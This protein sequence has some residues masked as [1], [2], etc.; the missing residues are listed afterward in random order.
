MT[1]AI[2]PARYGS[3]RLKGKPLIPV[4]GKP[5]IRRVYE[6]AKKAEHLSD[7][8]VATD[9]VRVKN[10]VEAFSGK[11]VLTES[12]LSSGTDRVARAAEI[13]EIPGD[14]IVVNIQGDQPVFNPKCIAELLRPFKE[15]RTINMSTLAY[16][17]REEREITDPKDVKVTFDKN[18][19]ALYFSRAAI[20]YPR[21]KGTKAAYYKHLGFYAYRKDFLSRM[22]RLE[23]GYYE[24]IEKLEQLKI[25]EYG[26]RIKIV[27]TA[28]DSPEVDLP[29][30]IGR[31]ES[32]HDSFQFE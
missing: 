8:V 21:D 5:M 6:Q 22:A 15:D 20:P 12:D 10:A 2:I 32:S 23:K 31:I 4:A 16:R 1:I 9:D 11:A 28:H 30:D 14:E 3:S 7:V 13:L 26:F 19:Y 29:E 25:L 17:I 27:I 18:G 24:D